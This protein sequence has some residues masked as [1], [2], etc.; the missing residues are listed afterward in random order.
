[1]NDKLADAIALGLIKAVTVDPNRQLT[2]VGFKL[3]CGIALKKH[4]PQVT[5]KDGSQWLLDYVEVPIGSEGYDWS[6]SAAK[7][8]ARE[9]V[10]EFGED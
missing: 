5:I 4:W 1:M 3:A 6:F 10:S 7:D 9:Y 2:D 8:I